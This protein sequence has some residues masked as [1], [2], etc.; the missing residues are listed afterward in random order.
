[1]IAARSPGTAPTSGPNEIKI[2][3]GKSGATTLNF[4]FIK[5]ASRTTGA[6]R[7]PFL[8][9]TPL[10]P[11]YDT[12]TPGRPYDVTSIRLAFSPSAFGKVTF[13]TPSL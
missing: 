9:D 10:R 1:M 7:A 12:T 8:R 11:C 3:P 5:T 4:L 2:I 13:N 6:E